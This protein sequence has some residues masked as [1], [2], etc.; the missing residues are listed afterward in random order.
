MVLFSYK[1]CIHLQ[2][3]RK[4][5]MDNFKGNLFFSNAKTKSHGVAIEFWEENN[6]RQQSN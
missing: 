5:W 3:I 6:H 4:K 2:K 1:K